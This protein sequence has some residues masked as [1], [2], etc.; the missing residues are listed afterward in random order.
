[1]TVIPFPATG[2]QAEFERM[3]ARLDSRGMAKLEAFMC[4]LSARSSAQKNAVLQEGDPS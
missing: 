2:R 1:M 3:L 4:D